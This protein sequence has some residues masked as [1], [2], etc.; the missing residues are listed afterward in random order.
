MSLNFLQRTPSWGYG[1][2][3]PREPTRSPTPVATAAPGLFTCSWIGGG[4]SRSWRVQ[5]Q[6]P[7]GGAGAAIAAPATTGAAAA[8]AAPARRSRAAGVRRLPREARSRASCDRSGAR[9]APAAASPPRP[10][11]R[12]QHALA[13]GVSSSRRSTAQRRD[14]PS[15]QNGRGFLPSAGFE[16]RELPSRSDRPR[17]R[18]FPGRNDKVGGDS[19]EQAPEPGGRLS[20]R[21]NSLGAPAS[22]GSW[23]ELIQGDCGSELPCRQGLGRHLGGR[24]RVRRLNLLLH[25]T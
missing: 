9:R 13:L 21:Y 15:L 23:E 1:A 16:G 14:A 20:Q 25:S 17:G 2:P 7:P 3:L 18:G 10:T 4:S 22:W 11:A 19:P 6:A 5:T 12:R 8:A 24:T